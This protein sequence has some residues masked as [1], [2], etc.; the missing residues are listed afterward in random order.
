MY[1]LK[2]ANRAK[3]ELKHLPKR[4]QEALASALD[5]LKEDPTLGKPLAKELTGRFTFRVGMY[6]I[7]YKINQK[8]K[9]I[10]VFSVGHRAVVYKKP[11][12]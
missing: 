8:D 9:T 10:S 11:R 1:K 5:E 7:I 3:K 4:Y 2:L 6:R 12:L